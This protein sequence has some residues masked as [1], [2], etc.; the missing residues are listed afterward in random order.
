[1]KPLRSWLPQRTPKRPRRPR[2]ELQQLED[3]LAPATSLFVT[4]QT[5]FNSAQLKEYTGSTLV[6]TVAIPPGVDAPARDLVAA[7]GQVSVYNGTFDP[8][9][10]TYNPTAG[11]WSNQTADGWSTVNNVSY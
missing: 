1:M 11:T 2:L 7:D 4:A 5:S 3:R 10:S 8:V 9:L 6:R